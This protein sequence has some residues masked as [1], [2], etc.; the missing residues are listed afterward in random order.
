M[1]SWEKINKHLAIDP[2]VHLDLMEAT[3][4]GLCLIFTVQKATV[5]EYIVWSEEVICSKGV[6]S[7]FFKRTYHCFTST[8]LLNSCIGDEQWHCDAKQQMSRWKCCAVLCF[9]KRIEE[10][11][12]SWL[13]IEESSFNTS[14]RTYDISCNNKPW[15]Q[16]CN[17]PQIV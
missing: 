8:F 7:L 9:L 1:N 13:S 15:Y 4:S 12:R 17:W 14:R 11:G 6:K 2:S 3:W 16:T 5:A 10:A